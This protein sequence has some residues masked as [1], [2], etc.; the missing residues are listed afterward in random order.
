VAVVDV[1][2]VLTLVDL[3]LDFV[4]DFVFVFVL[5]FVLTLVVVL[6]LLDEVVEVAVEVVVVR[7][8]ILISPTTEVTFCISSGKRVCCNNCNK[9]SQENPN[10]GDHCNE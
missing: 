6:C 2:V 10:T 3:V 7:S 5:L 4:L 8:N 1:A 9:E